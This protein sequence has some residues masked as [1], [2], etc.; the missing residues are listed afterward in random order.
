MSSP[1]VSIWIPTFNRC[2]LLI[3]LLNALGPQVEE[4]GGAVEVVVSDNDSPDD[5]ESRGRAVCEKWGFR[6][7]RNTANI[8]IA[9]NFDAAVRLCRGTYA[10]GL[11]DDELVFPGALRRVVDALR[12]HSDAAFLFANS[13]SRFMAERRALGR[14]AAAVDFGNG[15]P[16]VSPKLEDAVLGD[17]QELLDADFDVQLFMGFYTG[18]LRRDLW[19]AAAEGLELSVPLC[20]SLPSTYPHCVIYARSLVGKKAVFLAEP[21]TVSFNKHQDWRGLEVVIAL[22]WVFALL[23]LYEEH[24][25]TK[26]RVEEN[27]K[28]LL[29]RSGRPLVTWAFSRNV[30]KRNLFDFWGHIRRHAL[31]PQLYAGVF[32]M[33]FWRLAKRLLRRR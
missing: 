24:G 28:T 13:C 20:E 19:L 22:V 6:Y 27:R 32:V 3:D 31:Y 5:T 15:P 8:G 16:R 12:R 17:W 11:G 29:L 2:D 23:D 18:V 26:A 33:P 9:A 10:W 25:V 30:E 14:P 4:L 7:S 21:C 1:L